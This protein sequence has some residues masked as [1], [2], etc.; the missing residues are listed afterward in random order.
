MN[1]EDSLFLQK[2]ENAK[3][4]KENERL[5]GDLKRIRFIMDGSTLVASATDDRKTNDVLALCKLSERVE[6]GTYLPQ[7]A[8]YKTDDFKQSF[9]LKFTNEKSVDIVINALRR[10]KKQVAQKTLENKQIKPG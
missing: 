4:R 9:E 10:V 5:R 2:R 6:V 7:Y 8:G 1:I 3:L